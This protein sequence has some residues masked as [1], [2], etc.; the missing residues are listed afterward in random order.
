VIGR[1]FLGAAVLT[2]TA[3]AEE[4][5][6]AEYFEAHPQEAVEV[7]ALCAAGAKGGDECANAQA[8]LAAARREARMD[9]YRR[10]F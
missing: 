4:P 5:R 3:C 9:S 10:Q 1:L 7:S 8:G 6:S 2:L